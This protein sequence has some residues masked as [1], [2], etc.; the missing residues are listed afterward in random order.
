M[1]EYL[2]TIMKE[3]LLQKD[4]QRESYCY[5]ISRLSKK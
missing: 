3:I 4:T 5:V 2:I 1:R